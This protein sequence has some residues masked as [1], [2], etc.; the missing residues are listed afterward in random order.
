ME[1]ELQLKDFVSRE[2]YYCVSSLIHELSQDEKFMEDILEFSSQ[3]IEVDE[4]EVEYSI[5]AEQDDIQVRGNALA[6]GDDELD[7]KTE[8]EILER[9]ENGDIWAWAHVVVKAKWEGHEGE[10]SLGGCSYKSEEDFVQAG[11]YYNDMKDVALDDLKTNVEN[12]DE[13]HEALEFWIVSDWLAGKL[14]DHGELV[15]KDFLGLTIWGRTTS[16]Q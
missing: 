6:S 9:L 5:I 2:V 12:A 11:D 4:D 13:R 15:T 10:D 16:G 1:N 8:N 14:E 7:T 3:Q